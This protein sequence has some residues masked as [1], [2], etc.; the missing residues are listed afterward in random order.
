MEIHEWNKR[1]RL[2]EHAAS[3]FE[4]PPTP[5]LVKTV[6]ALMPGRALDLACGTG[7]NALWLAERGWDVT[8]VDGALVAI[9]TLRAR[10]A[11]RGLPVKAFVADLEKNEFEIEPSRWDLIAICYYLQL[12]LFEPAKRGVKPGGVL[13]SIVHVAE[14]GQAPT[15]HSLRPGELETFFKGWEIL[16]RHEGMPNDAPHRRPVAEIVARRPLDS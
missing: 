15:R 9:E 1:Y 2:R 10:A 4:S 6:S 3:D 16:H 11:E 7:R 12:N 5:L 13:I 8:A 14:P